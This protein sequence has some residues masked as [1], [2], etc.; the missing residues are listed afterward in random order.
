MNGFPAFFRRER[1]SYN[2]D[3]VY[4][5]GHR[6]ALPFATHAYVSNSVVSVV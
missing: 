5:D 3:I 6:C 1:E 4:A 2:G